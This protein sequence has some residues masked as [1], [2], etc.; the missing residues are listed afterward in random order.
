[1]EYK[2]SGP[3]H[4]R[5][6]G[7]YATLYQYE[8][9]RATRKKGKYLPRGTVRLREYLYSDGH[10]G[11]VVQIVLIDPQEMERGNEKRVLVERMLDINREDKKFKE[12]NLGSQELSGEAREYP[13]KKQICLDEILAEQEKIGL[14]A[15]ARRIKDSKR[16]QQRAKRWKIRIRVILSTVFFI[17]G[18][19]AGSF[20]QQQG[21]LDLSDNTIYQDYLLGPLSQLQEIIEK[22]TR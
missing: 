19:V 13:D 22:V 7:R 16:K 17:L 5:L 9:P 10:H 14:F 20:L 18:L 4:G 1:M 3:T 6:N 8:F 21:L 11:Q 15:S 2:K 12:L